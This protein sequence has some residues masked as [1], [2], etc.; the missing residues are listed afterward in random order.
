M[1]SPHIAKEVV[2][3]GLLDR[4]NKELFNPA[5]FE[6]VIDGEVDQLGTAHKLHELHF[7]RRTPAGILL[8]EY[9]HGPGKKEIHVKG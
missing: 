8:T 5:G 9:D 2:A 7:A 1:K 3:A 4:A 6:L